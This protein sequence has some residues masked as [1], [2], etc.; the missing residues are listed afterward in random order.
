MSAAFKA[1]KTLCLHT[2]LDKSNARLAR[3]FVYKQ[4][5]AFAQASHINNCS[6]AAAAAKKKPVPVWRTVY[7]AHSEQKT[8]NLSAFGGK[9]RG[10]WSL[11]FR[12]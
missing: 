7:Y 11:I 1:I 9:T 8:V 2:M 6:S 12:V 3:W 4:S 5:L 10:A